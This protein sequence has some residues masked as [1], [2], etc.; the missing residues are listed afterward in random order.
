MSQSKLTK[1]Q[2]QYMLIQNQ[3][4][5]IKTNFKSFYLFSCSEFFTTSILL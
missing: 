4:I 3:L 1:I 2:L 5:R